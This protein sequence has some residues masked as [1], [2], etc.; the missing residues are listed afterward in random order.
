VLAGGQTFVSPHPVDNEYV[1]FVF[2]GSAGRVFSILNPD[3]PD[4]RHWIDEE[5]RILSGNGM[6]LSVLP[7]PL[8]PYEPRRALEVADRVRRI[9]GPKLVHAFLSVG[10]KRSPAAEA[11]VQ[12]FRSRLAP[13][14]P[15]LF[16]EPLAGGPATVVA[17]NVALGPPPRGSEFGG[18]LYRRGIRGFIYVG[19]AGDERARSDGELCRREGIDWRAI[20]AA[21][22]LLEL[23]TSGGPWY[24]YGPGLAA[25]R[26]RI[27]D[28][29][30]PAIP[31]LVSGMGFGSS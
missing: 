17:P 13:V 21:S 27:V 3:N 5:S 31:P 28:T 1:S 23:L 19:A 10:S 8:H 26:P 22:D 12:A 11:F 25:L 16:R 9:P 14:P 30:G 2:P 29:L 7:I 4:D 24:L 18:V 15:S 20:D 6:E